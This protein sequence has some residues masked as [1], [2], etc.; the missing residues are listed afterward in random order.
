MK[1]IIVAILLWS[2]FSATA[3]AQTT[4]YVDADT[5]RCND[6][7]FGT[8]ELP[9]GNNGPWCSI[10]KVNNSN[11][12][13][14]DSVLFKC[15]QMWRE[16]LEVRKSGVSGNAI[17]FSSYPADCGTLNKPEIRV[18][19][20]VSNW[21]IDPNNPSGN[22]YIAYLGFRPIQ[23]F[24][25]GQYVKL[26]QYPN[27]GYLTVESAA[28]D[29]NG[30]PIV[31]NYLVDSKLSAVANQ[32]LI[33]AGVRV[34]TER[35]HIQDRVV[36]LFEAASNKLVLTV[37][38]DTSP[39]KKDFG[40]YLDNKKWMLDQAGEWYYDPGTL[41]L[42]LWLPD[43]SNPN[44]HL[45]EASRNTFGIYTDNKNYISIANLGIKHAGLDGVAFVT[46][47]GL[48]A[49]NLAIS[50]SGRNGLTIAANSQG[51]AT[52]CVIKNSVNDGISVR[53]SDGTFI[54]GNRVENSGTVG[55]PKNSSAAIDATSSNSVQINNNT[56]TNTG[57]VGIRFMRQ[58]TVKNN[59]IENTCMV[60]DDCSAIYTWNGNDPTVAYIYNSEVSG[61]IIKNSVGNSQ[62]KPA[63]P[64]LAAG[65]YLDDLSNGIS[66]LNNTVV[67]TDA[68]IFLHNAYDNIV[69]GNVTYGNR[70]IEL[71][72]GEDIAAGILKAN[73]IQNNTLF[74]F[75]YAE[76]V[77]LTSKFQEISL[78]GSTANKFIKNRYSELYSDK[79]VSDMFPPNP[80][81][82]YF[83]LS[84]WKAKGM[85]SDSSS[86]DLLRIA[87]YVSIDTNYQNPNNPNDPHNFVSN[88]TF[89]I[90]AGQWNYGA[91]PYI[92]F[93]SA[94]AGG[95]GCMKITSGTDTAIVHSN[96]FDIIEGHTYLVVADLLSAQAGQSVKVS[97]SE[98]GP[99][100]YYQ[101]GLDRNIIVD[102]AW[103]TYNFVFKAT[104]SDVIG[105]VPN[106]Y[107]SRLNF[108]VTPGQ[109][110]YVDNV[111]VKEIAPND[112]SD[113]S[114][115]LLNRSATS[116]VTLA[117]SDVV[118]NQANCSDYVYFDDESKV[119]WPVTVSAMS[120]KIIVWAKNTAVDS[121]HDG[122]P[123][124][125]DQCPGTFPG[126]GANENG[127][128]FTQLHPAD[129]KPTSLSASRSNSNLVIN[130]SV[131]NQGATAAG[132]FDISF[133]LS[134]N[135]TY[136]A[137]DTYICSRNVTSL[138]AG[139]SN[140]TTGTV[141]T[142][143]PIPAVANGAY[144]VLTVD[145][146]GNTVIESSETNNT[147]ATSATLSL[148][149][150]LAPQAVSVSKSGNTLILGD[151]VKNQGTA[152]TGPFTVSFY[153][154]KDQTYQNG[155]YFICSRTV[156]S[157]GVGIQDPA[158]G[159]TTTQCSIPSAV[160]SGTYYVIVFDDATKT[161]IESNETNNTRATMNTIT[162]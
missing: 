95:S 117:C 102:S 10:A 21:N 113:D 93:V 1:K 60:L 28:T 149:P 48:L 42:Y 106:N 80:Y 108:Q 130:D 22:V 76:S 6:A 110:L 82:L 162:K 143:C 78:A 8:S 36:D 100:S 88:S 119:Y 121:D 123:D 157:L 144:Y 138:A 74:P 66:L 87:R 90:D 34:L 14:G 62:G 19:Q 132:V 134:T 128:S 154:S 44:T 72:L 111:V 145:D 120:S 47:L 139:V 125:I 160:P 16:T 114:A 96:N 17:T 18:S 84:Q 151:R 30:N 105:Q 49:D 107:G 112:P 55:S 69:Q 83:T 52:N 147:R 68:G 137:T 15:G 152:P 13:P 70:Q 141:K 2:V 29:A 3:F 86:F 35:Y 37:N 103:D 126:L 79:L 101:L 53:N 9:Q 155:D 109:Q 57:Y 65:I 26:A 25:D 156:N 24:V 89:D 7:W 97:V 46:S 58:S 85:D 38:T 91:S 64:T 99:L 158:S 142:T 67:N 118:T 104:K 4:Y 45:I 39:I 122:V 150:D 148:G 61:N 153:L 129:L 71:W 81:P 12:Q 31:S 54:I 59:V 51:T 23:V 131:I 140:P 27:S 5:S 32:E 94:C 33:G 159:T 63:G 77:N 124:G 92:S 11:F 136:E 43:S 20:V 56:V 75:I 40:Y 133:Y 98:G 73:T 127:C 41:Y 115:I 146:S 161:V 116:S 135:K 50:D